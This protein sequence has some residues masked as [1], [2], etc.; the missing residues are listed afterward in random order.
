LFLEDSSPLDV[1]LAGYNGDHAA[2]MM[3]CM[4]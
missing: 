3:Y 1:G 4:I 2:T